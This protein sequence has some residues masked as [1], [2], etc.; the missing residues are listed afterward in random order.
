MPQNASAHLLAKAR[1][2]DGVSTW[3][4]IKDILIPLSWGAPRH[5]RF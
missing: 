2:M 1:K 3:G 5:Q 4:E